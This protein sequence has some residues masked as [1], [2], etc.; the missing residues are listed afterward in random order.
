MSPWL[1]NVYMDIVLKEMKMGIVK[2]R[3]EWRFPGLFYAD[4]LVLYDEK[5][6]DLK[7]MVSHF[8]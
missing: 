8:V 4:D 2:E 5:E 6:V 7:V 1:F 3:R